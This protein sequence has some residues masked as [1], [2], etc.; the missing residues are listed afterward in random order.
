MRKYISGIPF[1]TNRHYDCVYVMLDSLLRFHGWEPS[2]PCFAH[3]DFIYHRQDPFL[4]QGRA[5]PLPRTLEAFGISLSH[6]SGDKPAKAWRA[7]KELIGGDAPVA[8]GL[9]VFPLAQA[10][11]YP[12]LR[13]SEHQFIAAGYDDEAGTVHLVDPSPWQPAARDIPLDLFL[14]C[15]DTSAIHR[16]E[17]QRSYNWTWLKVPARPPSLRGQPA[18]A[19]LRRNLRSMAASSGRADVLLGLEGIEEL[20]RDAGAWAEYDDPALRSRLRRCSEQLLEIALSREGHG[21][22]LRHLG[23]VHRSPDLKDLSRRFGVISQS[24]FVARNLCLKGAVKEPDDL[25]PRIQSRLQNIAG[26]E[27]EALAR[28]AVT[29]LS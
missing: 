16:E 24:W 19:L 10:G 18:K 3:W 2:V 4:L 8:I 9:D 25:V 28:L 23:Q 11:L 12:R 7:V 1:C 21:C 6:G 27:G 14:S 20:A 22:F 13:H 15:W 17:G 26:R 5:A 29:V